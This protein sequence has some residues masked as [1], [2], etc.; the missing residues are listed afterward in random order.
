[1]LRGMKRV[2]SW[3]VTNLLQLSVLAL[4]VGLTIRIAGDFEGLRPTGGVGPILVSTAMF[5][6][7]WTSL[8]RLARVWLYRLAIAAAL[9]AVAATAAGAVSTVY[10]VVPGAVAA[11]LVLSVI[12]ALRS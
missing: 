2:A 9:L 10:A 6:I 3:N 7:L 1:M 4:V 11:A 5:A 12:G 8:L